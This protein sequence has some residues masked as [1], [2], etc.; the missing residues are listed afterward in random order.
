MRACV[1]V[2]ARACVRENEMK[3]EALL[4]RCTSHSSPGVIQ[5]EEGNHTFKPEAGKSGRWHF[6]D[7]QVSSMK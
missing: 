3:A 6:L 2:R 7:I 5:E 1:C 4:E